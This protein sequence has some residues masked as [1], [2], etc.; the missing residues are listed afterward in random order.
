V[1]L[2]R[3]VVELLCGLRRRGGLVPPLLPP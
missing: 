1:L 2:P 3:R